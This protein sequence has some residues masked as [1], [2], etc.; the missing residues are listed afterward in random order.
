MRK[1]SKYFSGLPLVAQP[2]SL[3]RTSSACQ[4]CHYLKQHTP[5]STF[6]D[7]TSKRVEPRVT[8]CHF[9][10][11]QRGNHMTLEELNCQRT[12]S[13]T[14]VIHSVCI[15]VHIC[16]YLVIYLCINTYIYIY[17]YIYIYQYHY[18]IKQKKH[19]KNMSPKTDII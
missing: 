8:G 15:F 10:D 18:F 1:A 11:T 7:H 3:N 13:R 4:T 6:I 19:E 16:I 2:V 12:I 5:F 14:C 17:K 9:R